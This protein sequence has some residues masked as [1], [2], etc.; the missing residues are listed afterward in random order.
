MDGMDGLRIPQKEDL[1]EEE[2]FRILSSAFSI[3]D[4]RGYQ[5]SIEG[6]D[7]REVY[8]ESGG[9]RIEYFYNQAS[10][11]GFLKIGHHIDKRT[12]E[13]YKDLEIRFEIKDFNREGLERFLK[14]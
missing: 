2:I 14:K 9:I 12:G 10:G 13:E 1:S 7:N 4:K 5:S 8:E 3:L 11:E 6:F